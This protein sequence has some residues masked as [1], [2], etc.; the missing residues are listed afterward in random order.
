MNKV[1][2]S[3]NGVPVLR[4]VVIDYRNPGEEETNCRIKVWCPQCQKY[5][6]HGWD[7]NLPRDHIEHRISHCY[8]DSMQSGYF[9]GIL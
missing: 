7:K 6:I 2:E 3:K 9:I 8:D 5:H 4:G 1:L